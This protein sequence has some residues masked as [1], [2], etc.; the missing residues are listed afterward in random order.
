MGIEKFFSKDSYCGEI[1]TGKSSTGYPI[2][3]NPE[4]RVEGTVKGIARLIQNP[5]TTNEEVDYCLKVNSERLG[6]DQ[7]TL[8]S[9]ALDSIN[10]KSKD[11]GSSNEG[12]Q[13]DI[14]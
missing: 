8:L 13:S 4:K 10:S 12:E 6:I 11:S 9:L 1:L 2:R 5:T 7:E 3:V 14:S